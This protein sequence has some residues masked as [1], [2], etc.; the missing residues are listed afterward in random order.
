M[1]GSGPE[2]RLAAI[3]AADVFGYSRLMG[4]DEEDTLARL[5]AH[6]KEVI[7]PKVAE[8]RGRMVKTAG[9]GLIVE[10][11]SV[12]DALHC[13]VHVQRTLAERNR[14]VSE[15]R[16]IVFR[17]GLNVGDIV[18]DE[19][20]VFGDGVNVAARLEGIADPGHIFVSRTVRDQLRGHP[21]FAFE[22]LGEKSLKNIST[23][24]R[25]YRVAVPGGEEKPPPAP[26]RPALSARKGGMTF[27]D[28]FKI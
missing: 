26:S 9:D 13:A 7:D 24:V 11:V 4:A 12:V 17:M 23:P 5:R 6:R 18:V 10:F 21:G 27:G 19:G 14:P 1:A 2:R 16:R 15:E 3:L 25:V 22:D 8:H 28:K 20:D